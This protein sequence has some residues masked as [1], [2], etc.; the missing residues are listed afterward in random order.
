MPPD[1]PDAGDINATIRRGRAEYSD[2]DHRSNFA[3]SLAA[4]P[5]ELAA[6]VAALPHGERAIAALYDDPDEATRI[7]KLR[8]ARLGA[9]L[10]RLSA[11]TR[12]APAAPAPAPK[13]APADVYD[14]NLSNADFNRLR[15]EQWS[16]RQKLRRGR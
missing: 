7:L 14:P 16:A 4:E 15:D 12:A 2:F 13:A 5:A 3:V 1:A 8:G 6:A 10:G 9:E 11:T